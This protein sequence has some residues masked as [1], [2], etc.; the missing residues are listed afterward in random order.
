MTNYSKGRAFEYRVKRYLEDKG[1]VVFRTAGSHSQADLIALKHGE[2]WLVQCKSGN[3][4]LLPAEKDKLLTLT[5]E[6]GVT[7]VLATK[8]N[9]KQIYCQLIDRLAS[10]NREA[11]PESI[12]LPNRYEGVK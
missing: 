10:E 3:G 5:G 6:L 12:G 7:P 1:F 2:V 8:N 4:Y 9:R 11:T